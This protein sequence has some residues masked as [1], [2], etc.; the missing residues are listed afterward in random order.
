MD[1]HFGLRPPGKTWDHAHCD[2]YPVVNLAQALQYLWCWSG[3]QSS[4]VKDASSEWM[5]LGCMVQAFPLGP[6]HPLLRMGAGQ[7]WRTAWLVG[8]EH[9]TFRPAVHYV[10]HYNV[11]VLLDVHRNHRLIGDRSA[12]RPPPL[13]HTSWALTATIWWGCFY[14]SFLSSLPLAVSTGVPV[15]QTG[16]APTQAPLV[17]PTPVGGRRPVTGASTVQPAA[18]AASP[19]PSTTTTSLAGSRASSASHKQPAWTPPSETVSFF[20]DTNK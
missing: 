9:T 10:N 19:S 7:G 3:H 6:Q 12:G 11:E 13:S 14:T 4:T 20:T 8:F 2:N 16:P 15:V 5:K 17:A 18:T 1:V